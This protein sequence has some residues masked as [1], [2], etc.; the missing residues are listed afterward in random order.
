MKDLSEISTEELKIFVK[1]IE[2]KITTRKS[3][4]REIEKMESK[5][6][7]DNIREYMLKL[8]IESLEKEKL[9]RI[10]EIASRQSRSK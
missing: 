5:M 4:L 8:E 1:A 7:S 2:R 9:R 10:D 3:Q 6:A